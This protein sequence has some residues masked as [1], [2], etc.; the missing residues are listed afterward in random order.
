MKAV[1]LAGGLGTRISEETHL[2]KAC[3]TPVPARVERYE[4]T[5]RDTHHFFAEIQ[6]GFCT[7]SKP[8]QGLGRNFRMMRPLS[9]LHHQYTPALQPTVR[10]CKQHRQSR[11]VLGQ[12]FGTQLVIAELALAQTKCVFNLGT[13]AGLQLLS[14]V[15]PTA[16]WRPL[17]H[18]QTLAWKHGDM[19]GGLRSLGRVMAVGICQ[20]GPSL[21]MQKGVSLGDTDDVG[22][23]ANWA[24]YQTAIGICATV[25]FHSEVTLLTLLG[26]VHLRDVIIRGA[27]AGAGRFDQ[28]G[29]HY[30]A[31][32]KHQAFTIQGG[33]A[34]GKLPV[35]E[36]VA[37][38]QMIEPQGGALFG[39]AVQ[40]GLQ[41]V[42]FAIQKDI[43][44]CFFRVRVRKGK[45]MVQEVIAQHGGY[46]KRRGN[47][48][49]RRGARFNQRYRLRPWNHGLHFIKNFMLSRSLSDQ[50]ETGGGIAFLF[51]RH[52]TSMQV[53]RV[54][55][56][57]HT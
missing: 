57:D 12:P 36:L 26:L 51:H 27:L 1:I 40:V 18:C 9:F 3:T 24:V 33:V 29:I 41:V 4:F 38:E 54:A 35:A 48:L 25:R 23:R 53:K 46:C 10:H 15:Q 14:L 37:F 19:S 32:F 8:L 43:G 5:R 34:G 39:Q 45:S 13:R 31:C 2:G 55:C 17:V 11:R 30:G 50:I 16:P 56:S 49:A 21:T 6:G 28:D 20:G 22:G 44:S 47:R 7:V 52:L 42:K